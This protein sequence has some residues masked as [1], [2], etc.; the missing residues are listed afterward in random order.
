VNP[1]LVEEI[2]RHLA[3]AL[4]GDVIDSFTHAS[5]I[6][7]AFKECIREIQTVLRREAKALGLSYI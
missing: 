5:A 1:A 3:N 4:R 6:G 2:R 7:G